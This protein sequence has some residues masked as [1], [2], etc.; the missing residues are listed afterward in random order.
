M[1][2]KQSTKHQKYKP[3]LHRPKTKSVDRRS[4]N[5]HHTT[6][7]DVDRRSHSKR[8]NYYRKQLSGAQ[9]ITV[10]TFNLDNAVQS[11]SSNH[12]VHRPTGWEE[13]IAPTLR[14]MSGRRVLR[15]QDNTGKDILI[16][17][18]NAIKEKPYASAYDAGAELVENYK[19]KHKP[20]IRH[21]QP[22]PVDSPH[23]VIH[24]MFW[25][26]IGHRNGQLYYSRDG[27]AHGNCTG[28]KFLARFLV[29]LIGV[30][31]QLSPLL[32]ALDPEQYDRQIKAVNNAPAE[33]TLL[34]LYKYM[35]IPG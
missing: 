23:G 15:V 20:S 11:R 25:H 29:A 27:I 7:A 31:M 34:K 24:T 35:H 19:F 5:T 18:P 3:Q 32:K 12:Y 4:K 26:A 2:I 16:Y 28:F 8:E 30:I 21:K 9:I 13:T 6:D 22:S 1:F 17:F 10:P 14:L 33:C